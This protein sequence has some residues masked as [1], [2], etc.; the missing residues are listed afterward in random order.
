MVKFPLSRTRTAA[1]GLALAATLSVAGPLATSISASAADC[2]FTLGF[3]TLHDIDATDIGECTANQAYAANGDAQQPT[4]RGLMVW[5]KAD[6]FTAFTDG[7]HTWVNG[8]SGVQERLNSERFSWEAPVNNATVAPAVY[9]GV[10]S[11]TPS[12]ST[13]G[14]TTQFFNALNS[15]RKANGEQPLALNSQLNQLAQSRAQGLLGT[16]GAPLNHY[17]SSGNLILRQLMDGNHIPYI[18]A[19]ENLAENNYDAGQ[20]VGVANTGLMNSPTHRANILNAGFTQVGIGLSGPDP[21]G[22]YY[23]VQLFLQS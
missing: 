2:Q 16:N 1:L 13:S 7:A 20:T 12:S 9:T 15:D 5:R 17:D 4:T 6:N 18:S 23:Y 14:M 21:V 11:D 22:R 10:V 3:K 19:G 8:P